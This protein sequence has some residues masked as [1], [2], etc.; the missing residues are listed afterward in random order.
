MKQL[1]QFEQQLIDKAQLQRIANDVAKA[2]NIKYE[3]AIE[4]AMKADPELRALQ[5]SNLDAQEAY[6][7]AR[8]D[9]AATKA[10]T[11][12]AL[13]AFTD[14]EDIKDIDAFSYRR[15]VEP[16]YEDEYEFVKAVA[17]SGFLFLLKPDESA[18]KAFVS[19]MAYEHKELKTYFMPDKIFGCLPALGVK[20]VINP[21][22]SDP[23]ISKLAT[24]K[25]EGECD[26]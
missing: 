4:K 8:S 16:A 6:K 21:T 11:I 25:T 5:T 22:I 1:K 2:A 12:D 13:L 7:T 17:E 15:S 10:N 18:I 26:E 24:A 3:A 9:Y 20:V 19:G 14:P 23:K